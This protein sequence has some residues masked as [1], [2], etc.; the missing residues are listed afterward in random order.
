MPNIKAH[1]LSG[2]EKVFKEFSM[3]TKEFRPKVYNLNNFGEGTVGYATVH[4]I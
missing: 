4:F 1:G 3:T 2:S